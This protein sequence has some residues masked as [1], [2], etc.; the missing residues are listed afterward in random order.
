[1]S[2][3]TQHGIRISSAFDAGSIEVLEVAEQANGEVR[4]D[5]A[6]RSDDTTDAA[7]DFRQWFH[8]RVQGARGRRLHMRFLNAGACTYAA[9]WERYQA[10]WSVDQEHWQRA[11]A[12]FDGSTMTVPFDCESD[13]VWFAYFE[14]YSWQRHQSLVSR[15]AAHASVDPRTTVRSLGTTVDGRD[16]DVVELGRPGGKP[17]WVIARQHPGETMAEWFV[18]GLLDRLFDPADSLARSVLDHARVH[19]VP[20]MNPD[21]S[22]RGNLRANA[23]GAN[24]NRE[25]LSPSADRSPEVLATRTAMLATGCEFFLDVHGDEALPYVFVAGSEMLPGFTTEQARLQKLFCDLFC[26][27]APDFQTLHGYEA[28]KYSADALKLASKWAGHEFGCL[29]LTLEMPFKDNANLPDASTGW[30]GARSKA[31]GAASLVPMAAVLG[32]G[33]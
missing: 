14:P 31:L 24:L 30:N 2:T 13:A 4:V 6:I 17:V 20:N 1:M 18:E 26:L 15:A 5:L 19:I 3:T 16:F 9:G 27:A 12:Q 33:S 23:A 8:F 29:S 22:V 32:I 10:C 25:W 21:G 11:P 7:C 28:G